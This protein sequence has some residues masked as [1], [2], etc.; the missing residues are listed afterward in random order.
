MYAGNGW[1]RREVGE[2]VGVGVSASRADR[3]D[4]DNS[5]RA[6]DTDRRHAG[7]ETGSPGPEQGVFGPCSD[8]AR[9]VG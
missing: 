1:G 6:G 2:W 4:C 8:R 3:V 7:G 9:P 5:Q